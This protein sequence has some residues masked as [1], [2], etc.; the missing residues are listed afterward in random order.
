MTPKAYLLPSSTDFETLSVYLCEALFYL[1]LRNSINKT[2]PTL[3][4]YKQFAGEG[5]EAAAEEEWADGLASGGSAAQ[6]QRMQVGTAQGRVRHLGFGWGEF[7]DSLQ[8]RWHFTV[9]PDQQEFADFPGG[10]WIQDS[11]FRVQGRRFQ[12]PGRES[13]I[14]Y[15][16]WAAKQ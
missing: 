15:T 1:H 2:A 3:K 7:R 4:E 11:D 16:V 10:P 14:L 9:R 8:R 13:K 6:G 5:R 12:F